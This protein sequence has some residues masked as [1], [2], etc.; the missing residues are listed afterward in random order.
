LNAWRQGRT[1]EAAD[2]LFHQFWQAYWQVS[3]EEEDEAAE[4]GEV[5]TCGLRIGG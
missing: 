1:A 3:A 4:L 2:R 5:H